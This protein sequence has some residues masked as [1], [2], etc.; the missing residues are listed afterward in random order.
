MSLILI[1]FGALIGQ[2][3]EIEWFASEIDLGEVKVLEDR[4]CSFT[5]RNTTTSPL[6]VETV[7]T[8]CGC[9][10]PKWPLEPI[11]SDQT[12]RISITFTPNRPGYHRKKIKVFFAGIRKGYVLWIEAEA[13]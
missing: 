4:T 5:F 8:S 11:L 10:E 3:Q 7:R 1:L 2:A 13:R 12:G 6:V 9:T